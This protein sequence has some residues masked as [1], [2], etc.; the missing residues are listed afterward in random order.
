MKFFVHINSLKARLALGA[1]ILFTF[2]LA[3]TFL[4]IYRSFSNFRKDEFYTRLHDRAYNTYKLLVEVDAIDSVLLQ[5][6]DINTRHSTV[7]QQKVLVFH[8]STLIYN[9]SSNGQAALDTRMFPAIKKNKEMRYSIENF[10]VVGLSKSYKGRD[11]YILSAGYD[12]YG[13]RQLS[14]LRWAMLIAF[15]SGTVIAWLTVYFFVKKMVGPLDK[16]QISLSKIDDSTL[17]SRLLETGQGEEVDLLAININQLLARLENAFGFRK[18]FVH[19]ASHELR[20]PL[21]AMISRTESALNGTKTLMQHKE[22][23]QQLLQQQK[24]LTDITTSL[25]LLSDANKGF[26][27]QDYPLERLDE[28][29][30]RS[31]EIIEDLIPEATIEV[32]VEGL[33][34]NEDALLLPANEPLFQMALSNLLKNALQYSSD[35]KA[36]ITLKVME[37]QK[38]VSIQ[39]TGGA[40]PH[41]EREQIFTPFYRGSTTRDIKGHGLGLSLV[42][43]I[44]ILHGGTIRYEHVHPHN[45][46]ILSFPDQRISTVK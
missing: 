24:Q 38:E 27:L 37:N 34:A 21:A 43:Q 5:I 19:Y 9:Y 31:A 29:V 30:F 8:D 2:L 32:N 1:G 26:P 18:D 3:V 16:L 25:L 33:P 28:M 6:I 17:H 44:T 42:K 14:F 15:V 45:L 4:T 23:L 22:V 13:L 10:E 46:F 12:L 35:N 20:T 11:Y 40:V 41:E 39:N 7:P 36:V